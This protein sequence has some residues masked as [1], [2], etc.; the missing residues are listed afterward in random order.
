[1]LYS[2]FAYMYLHSN[3]L[4]SFS[5][6]QEREPLVLS[7]LPST[8]ALRLLSRRPSTKRAVQQIEEAYILPHEATRSAKKTTHR[9]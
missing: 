9:L 1:M 5:N 4:P 7:Y 6:V 2:V 3:I 8:E